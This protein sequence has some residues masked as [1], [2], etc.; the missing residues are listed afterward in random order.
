DGDLDIASAAPT[1]N[2]LA[3]YQN[4]GS[5]TFSKRNIATTATGVHSVMMADMD[6]D[7][8]LDAVAAQGGN[9]RGTWYPNLPSAAGDYDGSGFVDGGDFLL[10]QRTFGNVANPPG[11]GA[12]GS[13]NGVIDGA[14]FAVW[15][16]VFGGSSTAASGVAFA[17]ASATATSA[18]LTAPLV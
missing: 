6:G 2:A 16:G 18:K 8:D 4:D 11:S 9:A 3:W 1:A 13:Q 10:W 12:D 15:K 7:G 5:Q 17:P 14:D